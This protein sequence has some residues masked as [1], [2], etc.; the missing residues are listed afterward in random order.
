MDKNESL[1]V[2]LMV[3]LLAFAVVLVDERLLRTAVVVLPALMLAQKAMGGTK[4]EP[5]A[6]AKAPDRRTDE[7]IRG[8]IDRLLKHF[9]EFYTTCHLMGANVLTPEAAEERVAQ[10]ELELNK[11]L[12]EVTEVAKARAKPPAK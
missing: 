4:A 9:R 12:A 5:P 6:P 2:F 3:L 10:L 11:F 1:S 7:E 8:Y